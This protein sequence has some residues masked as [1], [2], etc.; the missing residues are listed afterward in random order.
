MTNADCFVA[1]YVLKEMDRQPFG[2]TWERL[3]I[4]LSS[5]LSHGNTEKSLN[6]VKNTMKCFIIVV[7]QKLLSYN[8]W[9]I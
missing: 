8:F 4:L 2:K 7:K 9:M 6:S 1:L 5:Y 3:F